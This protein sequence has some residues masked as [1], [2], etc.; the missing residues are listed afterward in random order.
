LVTGFLD[1]LGNQK[2]VDG[3][4]WGNACLVSVALKPIGLAWSIMSESPEQPPAQPPTNDALLQGKLELL[5]LE[6]RKLRL[7][8]ETDK[9]EATKKKTEDDLKNP[10]LKPWWQKLIDFLALPAAVLA[11]AGGIITASNNIHT[12]KKTDAETNQINQNLAK[13]S[14][15]GKLATDLAEKQKEGPK[16]YQ[17]A[18][19]QNAGQI[20]GAL[21]RLQKI[22][23]H[24]DQQKIVQSVAKFILLWIL[25]HVVDVVFGIITQIWGTT[26]GTLQVTINS[27]RN[28]I[29]TED[30]TDAGAGVR[31]SGI[32]IPLFSF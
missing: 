32:S 19:A 14:E 22:D 28:S 2:G 5:D 7:Q 21:Q 4:A 26:L 1:T 27:W 25:F 3:K 8:A 29:D 16:A 20:Q 13:P 10:V 12:Q 30:T 11:L 18:V 31:L 9:L 24:P 23:E 6:M 17:Q 15:A